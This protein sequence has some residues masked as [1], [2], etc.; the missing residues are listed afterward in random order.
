[1]IKKVSF[2]LF[3]AWVMQGLLGC[4]GPGPERDTPAGSGEDAFALGDLS[5]EGS[6][7][8][9][10]PAPD[11]GSNP[12]SVG[13]IPAEAGPP[14]DPGPRA[15][16]RIGAFDL[17]QVDVFQA[18]DLSSKYRVNESGLIV[19][20]LI[21]PVKVGSLTPQEAQGVIAEALGRDYLQ[22]PQVT[23][24]VEEYASSN[25]TVAGA[26]ER[27]GVYP[28]T[29]RTSLL[30]AIA[31]SEGANDIANENQV[32]LFREQ[33][34]GSTRAYVVSLKE[35]EKGEVR[36]PQLVAGDRVVVPESGGEV[37]FRNVTNALRGFVRPFYF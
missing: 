31:L 21:G 15:T 11:E 27:P 2:C 32:I 7:R 30:Q 34:D 8:G 22:N 12:A 6:G 24:F 13:M 5:A 1:M 29:A 35:I 28:L 37:F 18:D 3:L 20:P 17:I 23:V 26:V 19:M 36:D 4:Q 33:E 25:I 9:A 16:Y 10:S 14:P